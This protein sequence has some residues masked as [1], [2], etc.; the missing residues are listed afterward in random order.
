MCYDRS[1]VIGGINIFLTC[2]VHHN[3]YHTS[4]CHRFEETE[5]SEENCNT[6][7]PNHAIT[8]AKINTKKDNVEEEPTGGQK[9][10]G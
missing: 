2:G 3:F 5:P 7:P 1:D 10:R 8:D 4:T 9:R 6:E